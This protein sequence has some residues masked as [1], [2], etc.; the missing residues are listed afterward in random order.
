MGR[1][2]YL[3]GMMRRES[4]GWL[5]PTGHANHVPD[6]QVWSANC[7]H[8]SL[9]LTTPGDQPQVSCDR[10]TRDIDSW[11]HGPG[12]HRARRAGY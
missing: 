10:P 5:I 11:L 6:A 4:V 2:G 9:F 8:L 7:D 3:G 1:L 12:D